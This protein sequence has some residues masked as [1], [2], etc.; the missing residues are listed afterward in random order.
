[1]KL[2]TIILGRVSQTQKDTHHLPS[3]TC[4]DLGVI[5]VNLIGM[6]WGLILT[7][8]TEMAGPVHCGQHHSL[9]GSWTV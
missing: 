7:I 6:R 5:S 4:R 1:M 9:A 2:E 8:L 3:L